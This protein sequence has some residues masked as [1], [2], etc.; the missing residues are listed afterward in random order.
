MSIRITGM[1][2]G[3]DT[4][5][6]I[7]E[8]VSAQS[9]KKNSL[10]KA[11]TKLSWKQ[12]AWKALN[13]K[14]YDFYTNTL[15]D[16]RYQGSYM[17]K[18]TKVS[19]TNAIDVVTSDSAVDGVRSVKVNQLAKGARLTSGSLVSQDGVYFS[20][21]A[22]LSQL[23][24]HRGEE[25][26][27]DTSRS[28]TGSFRVIGAQGQYLDFDVNENTT[29]DDVVSMIQST[30]LNANFD[31]DSQRI[32][33]SSKKTGA[34]NN[35]NLVANDEGGMNA[36]ACLGLLCREDLVSDD[37]KK[38]AAYQKDGSYTDDY[39][40]ALSNEIA[41]R[42][43]ELQEANEALGK[44]NTDITNENDKL[45]K[46]NADL[47]ASLT[48]DDLKNLADLGTLKSGKTIDEALN[49]LYGENGIYDTIAGKKAVYTEAQA[50]YTKAQDAYTEA[51]EALKKAQEAFDAVQ[52]SGT[53]EDKNAAQAALDDAQAAH[54]TARADYDT[55]KADYDTAKADYDA[56]QGAYDEISD[57][58]N[59]AVYGKLADKEVEGKEGSEF[60]GTYYQMKSEDGK[61]LNVYEKLDGDKKGTGKYYNSEGTLLYEKLAD[62]SYADKDGAPL[63]QDE[64]G[65]YLDKG[66]NVIENYA[67]VQ[68]RP[69]GLKADYE[70]AKKKGNVSDELQAQVDAV[71][72][73]NNIFLTVKENKDTV[74]ANEKK[75][76]SNDATIASNNEYMSDSGIE[77]DVDNM[78]VTSKLAQ[79]VQAEFEAKVAAAKKSMEM[80]EDTDAYSGMLAGSKVT[81]QNAEIEIDGA[82]FDSMT[83]TFSVNGLTI[84]AN[85]ETE[86]EITITTS[87]DTE[88]TYNM[89]KNFFSEYNKL[90]NEMDS[91]YNAEAS[92][93]YEPL[94]SEEKEA[95][96]DSE[97]EE[98]EKKIKDSL[99]RR[100]TTLSS[101]SFSM[102]S[103]LLQ[104]TEVN[105][106][107]M[108]LSDFGINTLGYFNAKDNERNAY[109]IDGDADDSST[110]A[111]ED[112]LR[113]MIASD[114]ET[115]MNF[116]TKLSTSLYD[117]LTAKMAGTT[118]SSAMTVYNDKL[119]KSEYSD[120]TDKIKKQ[121]E[122]LNA[123]MDKWYKKFSQMETAMSKLESRSSSLASI[124]GG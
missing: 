21:A 97:I 118:L 75:I 80:A 122:K 121:E 50:A 38:W 123:M 51:Q 56:V 108:Y 14:I 119:M 67:R 102:A 24:K 65:N 109:H 7:S 27:G 116:F 34:L 120:Y 70:A 4:E 72:K 84:T 107:Q 117:N 95:L 103:V 69:G 90:I 111:N 6:I 30:G 94:L 61:A 23:L 54:D 20:G 62:G 18:T 26:F 63:K 104:G 48:E 115:V 91:L 78:A 42:M 79:D 41:S 85:E 15:S 66:G 60:A 9:V 110:K 17:K 96:S 52:A 77:D 124:L 28:M 71:N 89:I 58:I 39:Y 1:Y 101:I 92:T 25:V 2:S 64:D 47:L 74:T 10:V 33:I 114:P 8:L 98:W 81:A 40:D 31:Q 88:G 55:V 37:N 5:S 106:K 59:D 13:T 113:A 44:Q 35:F 73:L 19:N 3:L 49:D 86:K 68:E 76:A 82:K 53:E 46:D 32:F 29:I 112:K 87:Y 43:E 105:G 22:N 36:L 99:L 12:D 57:F 93:G 83:N 11:Q 16:M 100:D 45:T